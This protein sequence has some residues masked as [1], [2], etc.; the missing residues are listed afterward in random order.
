MLVMPGMVCMVYHVIPCI[1][2]QTRVTYFIK[3]VW[4][5]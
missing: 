2:Q 1:A 4:K 5:V 3:K